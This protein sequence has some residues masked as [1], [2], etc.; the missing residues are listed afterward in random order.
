M[1][2]VGGK[3]KAGGRGK[4]AKRP[5]KKLKR[6]LGSDDEDSL[7]LYQPEAADERFRKA[8]LEAEHDLLLSS[9]W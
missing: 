3:E 7:A 8:Q 9:L 2:C 4:Q 6:I 1:P 5:R